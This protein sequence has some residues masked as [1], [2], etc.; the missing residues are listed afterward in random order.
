MIYSALRWNWQKRHAFSVMQK[1]KMKSISEI[2]DIDFHSIVAFCC[3]K[4]VCSMIHSA[5]R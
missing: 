4:M 1:G 3:K 2:F 5:L